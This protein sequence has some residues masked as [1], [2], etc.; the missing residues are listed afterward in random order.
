M[1]SVEKNA[2]VLQRIPGEHLARVWPL[3]EQWFVDVASRSRGEYT[4]PAMA[5]KITDGDWQLWVIWDGEVLAVGATELYFALSGDKYCGVR[6]LTGEH[7]Y[8]WIHLMGEIEAWAKNEG[9]KKVQLIA[10]KGWARRMPDYA[11]THVMLEK[12][13]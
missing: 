13:I 6:F 2:P 3:V 7:S 11:M 1:A 5:K 8:K 10:R 9:C 12:D 4:A